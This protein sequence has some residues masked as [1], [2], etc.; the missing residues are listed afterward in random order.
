MHVQ[1]LAKPEVLIVLF[2]PEII[3][4]MGKL[5]P[6]LLEA[7]TNIA[8]A[9]HE[10]PHTAPGDVSENI[11]A[12]EYLESLMN[13]LQ[14]PQND[15]FHYLTTSYDD[16]GDDMDEDEDEDGEGAMEVD[17]AGQG[18]GLRR[19]RSS[20]GITRAEVGCHATTSQTILHN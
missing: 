17:Q 10:E 15:I 8:A 2:T 20:N 11:D 3:K 16:D 19:N 6:S 13:P 1:I 14:D 4:K 7:M 9:V 5:H 18:G 12:K